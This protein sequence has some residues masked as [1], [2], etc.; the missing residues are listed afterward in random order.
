MV[1][2]FAL[3]LLYEESK[4]K[5]PQAEEKT[6]EGETTK[7]ADESASSNKTEDTNVLEQA[8]EEIQAVVAAVQHQQQTGSTETEIPVETAAATETPAGGETSR[9]A[10]PEVEKDDQSKRIG[11]LGFFAMLF[12]RFCSPGDKKTD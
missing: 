12:E 7:N 8:V 9:E 1:L 3:F 4:E 11:F 10:K 2:Q 6:K 5:E